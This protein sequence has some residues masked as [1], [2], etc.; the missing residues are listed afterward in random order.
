MREV[1]GNNSI[2]FNSIQLVRRR[3][4]IVTNCLSGWGSVRDYLS[5]WLH[6]YR[7]LLADLSTRCRWWMRCRSPFG[8][9]RSPSLAISATYRRLSVLRQDRAAN[10]HSVVELSISGPRSLR[11]IVGRE[12]IALGGWPALATRKPHYSRRLSKTL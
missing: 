8:V 9:T 1:T 2:Q 5:V 4:R 11:A 6:T 12:D 3:N 7:P 10:C